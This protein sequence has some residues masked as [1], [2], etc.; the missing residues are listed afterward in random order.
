MQHLC[1]GRMLL[2]QLTPPKYDPVLCIVFV[3]WVL[4][5]VLGKH[6]VPLVLAH[7]DWDKCSVCGSVFLHGCNSSGHVWSHQMVA[8]DYQSLL[9][10]CC[11][12][13]CAEMVPHQARESAPDAPTC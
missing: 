2:P 11:S 10:S 4:R 7:I 5:Q 12:G 6:L 9:A 8:T 3:D 13:G 1:V